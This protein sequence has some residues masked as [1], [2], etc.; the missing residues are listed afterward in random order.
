LTCKCTNLSFLFNWKDKR[1][2]YVL[3]QKI[4][5]PKILKFGLVRILGVGGKFIG[6][7]FLK[8]IFG[9]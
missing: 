3:K 1:G 5:V 4:G 7:E 9:Y 6:Y 8:K 2:F